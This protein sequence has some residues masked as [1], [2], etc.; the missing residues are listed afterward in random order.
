VGGLVTS[1]PSLDLLVLASFAVLFLTLWGA[2]YA[3]IP[4]F[5]RNVRNLAGSLAAW[6]RRHAR[7]GATVGRLEALRS[8]LPLVL[9]LAIGM[10]LTI[11]AADVFLDLASALAAHDASIQRIDAAVYDWFRLHRTPFLN[12]MFIG[13]TTGGGPVG[14]SAIVVVAVILTARQRFRGAA[15]LAITTIGG[16][17]LSVLLKAHFTRQR[18]DLNDAILGAHGYSFPSGHAMNG[19]IV[20]CAIGY[21]AARAEKPTWKSKSAA[22]AALVTLDLAIAA[23]RLYLGVHWSSDVVAGLAAGLL[24]VTATTTGYELFRQYRLREVRER[25]ATPEAGS[26]PP[27][28]S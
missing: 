6:L 7:F 13:I 14:M 26:R 20:L 28:S 23:S 4:W 15:Y 12:S 3:S 16:T 17:L 19:T 11:V 18:P 21:L 9:A 27:T 1:G 10:V 22:F 5:L 2:A 24:W 8:Y 25:A